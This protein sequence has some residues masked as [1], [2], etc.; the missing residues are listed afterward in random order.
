MVKNILSGEMDLANMQIDDTFLT[1]FSPTKVSDTTADF[2]FIDWEV[3]RKDPPGL[4]MFPD[5]MKK[6]NCTTR[7][8]YD[9][10][11][12]KTQARTSRRLYFQEIVD[13]V[14]WYDVSH[15]I[16]TVEPT[17]FIFHESRCGSTLASNMLV[18]VDPNLTYMYSES[19]PLFKT[20]R[21]CVERQNPLEECN[22]TKTTE[23]LRDIMYMM[24]RQPTS[25]SV[26]KRVF[27]KFIPF[28]PLGFDIILE[29]FPTVPWIFIYRDPSEVMASNFQG[30]NKD[31]CL[32][33]IKWDF[34]PS[35][36]VDMLKAKKG[37]NLQMDSITNI[38]YCA[39]NLGNFCQ[40]AI[41]QHQK[42]TAD[43]KASTDTFMGKFVNYSNLKHIM[44]ERI[45]PDHFN[46]PFGDEQRKNVVK[47]ADEY[48]KRK[49][50]N[51]ETHR[52]M[53][54]SEN[55]IYLKENPIILKSVD[56]FLSDPY[57]YLEAVS[58]KL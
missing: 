58:E 33:N 41:L 35:S 51:D 5:L 28:D 37:E 20:I 14:K 22:R 45:I 11:G 4:P 34:L 19:Q 50:L 26:G 44:I 1:T 30:P 9:E 6:S 46:L 57:E 47:V 48:S 27:F 42:Y 12:E 25:S 23:L 53:G 55:K 31:F 7:T 32:N 49:G 18:A 56:L 15:G 24:T 8:E 40:A 13:L 36:L 16:Q 29:A 43:N 39:A 38:E 54:D 3:Y 52:W 17:G 2:C 10:D 21:A